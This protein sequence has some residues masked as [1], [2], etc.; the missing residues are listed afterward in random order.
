MN[1]APES[2]KRFRSLQRKMTVVNDVVEKCAGLFLI[3]MVVA[4]SISVFA[5]IIYSYA[6]IPLSAPWAEEVG[7]YMMIGSVFAGGAVAAY[8][9]RLIGF[10]ALVG[11]IPEPIARWLRLISHIMTLVLALLLVWKSV[12]LVELGLNVW[13]PAMAMPM[14][15]VYFLMFIGSVL[16]SANMLMHVFGEILKVNSSPHQV[17]EEV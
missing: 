4:V 13:S 16:L 1:R 3:G 17:F 10:D 2:H 12:R 15:Y 11:A 5:R 14:A 9:L 8:N 6:G 7:R